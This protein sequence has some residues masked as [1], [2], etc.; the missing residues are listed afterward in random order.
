[1]RGWLV[2]GVVAA[3]VGGGLWYV[4]LEKYTEYRWREPGLYD[5]CMARDDLRPEPPGADEFIL[6]HAILEEVGGHAALRGVVWLA[7]AAAPFWELDPDGN[8]TLVTVQVRGTTGATELDADLRALADEWAG[9]HAAV[10]RSWQ[11]PVEKRSDAVIQARGDPAGLL[12][13]SVADAEPFFWPRFEFGPRGYPFQVGDWEF[14]VDVP[15]CAFAYVGGAIQPAD[16]EGA[17]PAFEV[18]RDGIVTLVN[19]DAVT[20]RAAQKIAGP[21]LAE[22]GITARFGDMGPVPG[23]VRA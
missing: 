13:R 7:G 15:T 18:A 1:M 4:S 5:A 9:S 6:D 21:A 19:G 11:G 22:L 8:K 14:S 20:D 17:A 2:A 10:E 23:L 16:P 3:L 12:E